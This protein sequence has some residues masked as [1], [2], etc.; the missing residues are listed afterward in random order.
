VREGSYAERAGWVQYRLIVSIDGIG[1]DTLEDIKELLSGDEPKTI[2]FRGW[3]SQD[4]KM[5][6]Y[7]EMDYWPYDVEL[8]TGR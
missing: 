1:P 5:H 7:H 4:N 6:D 8:Y 2:I 3:S